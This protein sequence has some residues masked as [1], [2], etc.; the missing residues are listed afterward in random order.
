M[1][2]EQGRTLDWITG[3]NLTCNRAMLLR[4]EENALLNQLTN[5]LRLFT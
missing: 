5:L 4:I 3:A 1:E 2:E